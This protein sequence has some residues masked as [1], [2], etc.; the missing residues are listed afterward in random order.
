ML[1]DNMDPQLEE[2]KRLY[3]DIVIVFDKA[4]YMEQ[5]DTV[6]NFNNPRSVVYARNAV[7][8]IAEQKELKYFAQF[9]DDIGSFKLRY[10][11]DGKLKGR[12]ITRLDD[13]I[14]AM[15]FM[16]NSEHVVSVGFGHAGS[17]IG[18]ATGKFKEKVV[19]NIFQAFLL[20][21]EQRIIFRGILNED[22]NAL[23]E[24][25]RIGKLMLE[26]LDVSIQSP[27]RRSNE[28]GL[29][30]LYNASNDYLTNFY[31]VV[32]APDCV[33]IKISDKGKL[34]LKFS[35]KNAVPKLI[36]E[37]WKK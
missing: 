11:D 25:S 9:D 30:E 10:V 21:T 28:G 2:Y 33:Y 27:K 22:T 36:N 15:I 3:G 4:K 35:R 16:L 8:D 19:Q 34:I 5:V 13:V 6:D 7:Y 24:Y 17:Y 1:V 37:R 18:G 14:I 12:Q 23:T 26:V 31:S 29:K 20:K 32:C